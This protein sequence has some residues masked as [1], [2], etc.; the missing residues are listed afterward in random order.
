[1]W[2]DVKY[3]REE[4]AKNKVIKSILNRSYIVTEEEKLTENFDDD[5]SNPADLAIPLS[6]DSSQIKA[7]K[8]CGEGKSFILQGPPGT[9]KS[10]TI[11]NM[12]VNAIYHGK[13]VLFVAEKMAALEVV[14]RRL[15]IIMQLL[16]FRKKMILNLVYQEVKIMRLFCYLKIMT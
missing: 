2:Q 6:A 7:I 4:L 9:G 11:T 3:H 14:Q 1:M 13:T 12:I 5:K 16:N 15:N 10:Q 8:D